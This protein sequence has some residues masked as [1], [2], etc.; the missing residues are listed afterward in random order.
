MHRLRVFSVPTFSDLRQ[1]WLLCNVFN[2]NLLTGLSL[3]RGG[4]HY[5]WPQG[6]WWQ[7]LDHSLGWSAA[8]DVGEP[9]V[10]R[11]GHVGDET[12]NFDIDVNLP[13]ALIRLWINQ[14]TI[15]RLAECHSWASDFVIASRNGGHAILRNELTWLRDHV[16][17]DCARGHITSSGSHGLI[18]AWI[19]WSRELERPMLN[20]M[21]QL[22]LI[23]YVNSSGTVLG[24]NHVHTSHAPSGYLW[25]LIVV[26][27]AILKLNEVRLFVRAHL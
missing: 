24:N 3:R 12:A 9:Y 21:P 6:L 23:V 10:R 5:L 19:L 16:F 1:E 13:Y 8:S 7:D 20:S 25:C 4:S 14:T 15:F 11:I 26:C 18:D 27:V 2:N 17:V 22:V